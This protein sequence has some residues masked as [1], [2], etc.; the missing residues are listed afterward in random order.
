MRNLFWIFTT[1]EIHS[2]YRDRNLKTISDAED[3]I[4]NRFLPQMERLGYGNYLMLIKEGNHKIGGV[5]IFEREGL[6]VVDI[7][8]SFR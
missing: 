2:V 7:G 6:D 8:F 1:V 4:R 5:G 3:Y